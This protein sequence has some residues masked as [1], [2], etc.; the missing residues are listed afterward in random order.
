MDNDLKTISEKIKSAYDVP[1][2]ENCMHPYVYKV[3]GKVANI[4]F[5]VSCEDCGAIVECPHLEIDHSNTMPEC[6]D[7]GAYGSDLPGPDWDDIAK[8]EYNY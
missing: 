8:Y 3:E 6:V 1:S 2:K 5:P 4:A 7:C